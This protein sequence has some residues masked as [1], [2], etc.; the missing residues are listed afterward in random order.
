[1]VDMN[2]GEHLSSFTLERLRLAD[3]DQRSADAA[4]SHLA[5]CDRCRGIDEALGRDHREFQHDIKPRMAP[6]LRTRLSRVG[7]RRRR[8]EWT[9][10]ASA[11]LSL[12]VVGA[13][14]L[15]LKRP[16]LSD[17]VAKGGGQLTMFARRGQDVRRVRDGDP[18]RPGDAVRFRINPG[19]ASYV[20]IASL[21]AAGKS[22]IY[23]PAGGALSVAVKSGAWWEAPGSVVL[24]G[25]TGPE[26]IYALFSERPLPAARVDQALAEV[27]RGGAAA[28]RSTARLPLDAVD[29]ASL[30]IEKVR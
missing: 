5:G 27:A 19:E 29:Q 21:D 25:T 8:R 1:M 18:L 14:A 26:R 2:S 11:G 30:L 3:L 4:R 7:V 10:A 15:F 12:L 17:V 13:L 20:L 28:I 23:V 9:L 24:D 22:T 6:A 16:E